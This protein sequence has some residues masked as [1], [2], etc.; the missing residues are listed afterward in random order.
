MSVDK[1]EN[2][3]VEDFRNKVTSVKSDIDSGA[4][5]IEGSEMITKEVPMVLVA[6]PK[7]E[8]EVVNETEDGKK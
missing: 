7:S 4:L 3:S 8:L 6:V 2:M 5:V 1:D